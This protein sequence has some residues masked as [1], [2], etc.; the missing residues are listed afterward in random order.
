MC[1]GR[2]GDSEDYK[3]SCSFLSLYLVPQHGVSIEEGAFVS[4]SL[5]NSA[6]MECPL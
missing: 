2:E 3:V 4:G 6:F 1:V 5:L